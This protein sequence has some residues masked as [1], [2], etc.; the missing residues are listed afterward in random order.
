MFS[1]KLSI[2]TDLNC[3][4]LSVFVKDDK[5]LQVLD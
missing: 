5:Q 3:L 1:Y 2:L 4:V